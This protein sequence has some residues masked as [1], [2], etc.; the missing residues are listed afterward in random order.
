M[1]WRKIALVMRREY[2][3]NFRRPSFLFTAFG[4][5]AFSFVA[6]FL[7]VQ[8][9][10]D[11]E[12]SLAKY[13]NV[14]YIDRAAIVT[15]RVTDPEADYYAYQPVVNPDQPEP[16][17]PAA[18]AAYF[19]DLQAYATQQVLEDKL[20]AYFVIEADYVVSGKVGLYSDRNVPEA[21]RESVEDFLE[22]QIMARAPDD[23]AIPVERLG[24]ANYTIR[25]LDSGKAL[26]EAA[27]AGRLLLPFIF[28]MIYFMA[29]STTAQFLMSGVVEEKENR[30]M[31]ILATSLRPL[32]LL[33]GKL[34]GLGAL[35]ITQVMV[36]TLAGLLIALSNADA[37]DFVT[38]VSFRVGDVVMLV[39]LFVLNFLVFSAIM[40]GIGAAVTAEA[41]S[42][43]IAG[44]LTFIGVLPILFL[45]AFFSNPDGPLPVFFTFFP[46]TAAVGLIM[47]LGMTT[48][49][50]WQIALSLA[51]QVVSVMAVM[52]LA[53]KVFRL[54]MLMY[55]KRLSP[56]ALWQAIREG[57]TTLTTASDDYAS[58]PAGRKGWFGR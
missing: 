42:R 58:V 55:G 26:S 6:M 56:R 22:Y 34:L 27:L 52:W 38:G 36:W 46:L 35:A 28:V 29:T 8:F 21:L 23:L 9:T 1:S 4:V 48:L 10:A 15:T 19:D 37:Q 49:P 54:G 7:I 47:R 41:E 13:H 43:Q 45:A 31:E 2:L 20:D 11:R 33:W 16:N 17:D 3:F 40:L 51:I 24:D 14:G 18:L 32:E 57:R 30:L 44:F 53:A 12:T 5:P 39:M 50:T 25:D